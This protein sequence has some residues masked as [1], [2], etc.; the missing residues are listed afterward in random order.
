[1]RVQWV[2][3]ELLPGKT[4]KQWSTLALLC[5][6]VAAVGA[7]GAVVCALSIVAQTQRWD[8]VT[9]SFLAL[10]GLGFGGGWIFDRIATAK[11]KAEVRAGYT[12]SAQGHN[13]V[14]YLHSPTGVVMREAGHPNLTKPEWDTAMQR[15][16]AYR[17]SLAELHGEDEG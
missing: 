17:A 12:T 4:V 9:V 15:V 7:A 13:D 5:F 10:F 16:N 14:V 1:M 8:P 2:K 11:E 6:A 3:L